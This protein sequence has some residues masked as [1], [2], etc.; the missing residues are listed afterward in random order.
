VDESIGTQPGGVIFGDILE[1]DLAMDLPGTTGRNPENYLLKLQ[2]AQ[3]IL[4]QVTQD[5][6]RKYQSVD[7]EPKNLEVTKFATGDFVL[8]TSQSSAKQVGGYVSRSHG[9]H[10]YWSPGFG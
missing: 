1:W 8:L 9:Y 4:V 2:G 6:L 7:G 10:I 5:Y 3:S